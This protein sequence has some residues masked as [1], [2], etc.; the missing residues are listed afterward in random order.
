V[1]RRRRAVVSGVA[2]FIG[3]N[4]AERLL[5]EG[6]AVVGLDNL[7]YG[8]LEQVPSGVEFHRQDI[9]DPGVERL[10][11]GADVVFHLAAKRRSGTVPVSR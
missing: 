2:G 4:L 1:A 10:F 11:R 6:Y 8:V 3:S 7:S 9:R 5:A